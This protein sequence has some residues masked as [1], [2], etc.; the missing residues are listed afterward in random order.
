MHDKLNSRFRREP[1]P[2]CSRMGCID[3]VKIKRAKKLKP[4]RELCPL[5]KGKGFLK[6]EKGDY[7]Q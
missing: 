7:E 6:I 3:V 2:I 1:C 5:C 4:A